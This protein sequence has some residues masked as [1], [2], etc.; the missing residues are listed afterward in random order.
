M[1][2]CSEQSTY[3][4]ALLNWGHIPFFFLD[5][6]GNPL[7]LLVKQNRTKRKKKKKRRLG[8]ENVFIK[9]FYK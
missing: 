8:K 9:W 3:L 6:V 5:I 7:F 2:P 1:L 4:H